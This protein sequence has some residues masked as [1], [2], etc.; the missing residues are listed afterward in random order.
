[1]ADIGNVHQIIQEKLQ[2]LLQL[3]QE[4]DNWEHFI[5]NKGVNGF[6]RALQPEGILVKAIGHLNCDADRL[7]QTI[8]NHEERPKWD[9][10]C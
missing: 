1:M 3:Y 9:K 6:R 7:I 10:G 4:T 2:Q 5:N 8:Y